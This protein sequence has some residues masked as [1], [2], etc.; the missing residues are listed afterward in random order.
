MRLCQPTL[1]ARNA[2][3]T[4]KLMLA[5]IVTTTLLVGCGNEAIEEQKTNPIRPVFTDTAGVVASNSHHQYYGEVQ[6]ANR[7]EIGFRN[8]GRL[9]EIFFEEGEQV[10]KGDLI[11]HLDSRDAEIFLSRAQIDKDNTRREYQRAKQ[12]FEQTGAIAK[13]ELEQLESRF[14]VAKSLVA[15]AERQLEYTNLYAPFNG[16]VARR[17]VENHTLVQAEQ[18]IVT[19]HDLKNLEV[20]IQVPASAMQSNASSGKSFATLRNIPGQVFDLS[21]SRY[22]TEP[23]PVTHTYEITLSFDDIRDERVIPGMAAIVTPNNELDDQDSLVMVPVSAI[24]PNNMGQQFVWVVKSDNTLERREVEV[25]GIDLDKVQIK[26]N[27]NQGEQVVIAGLS[28]LT[29]GAL[30][31]VQNH[32]AEG[33]K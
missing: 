23:N 7:A 28:G 21:L 15:E 6:S 29:E 3:P 5:T 24:Q 18:P 26:S 17:L 31:R 9:D 1:F 8:R 25:G 14:L 27:L 10:S 32:S 12:L 2:K 13:A 16:I 30:V 33:T 22:A 4:S 19:L 20:V 11:A